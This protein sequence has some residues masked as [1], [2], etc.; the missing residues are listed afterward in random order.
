[1]LLRQRKAISSGMSSPGHSGF[2]IVR[3]MFYGSRA[4][5][6]ARTGGVVLDRLK[7]RDNK[8]SKKSDA[9]VTQDVLDELFWDPAVTVADLSVSTSDHRVTLMGTTATYGEKLEAEDAAYRVGGVRDV[10][11]DI[12]VDSSAF[13]MRSDEDIAADV[14]S[15]LILDYAVPDD[16][17]SVSVFEGT[18]TLAGNVDWYYQRLAAADDVAMIKGVKFVDN[19]IA[20]MQPEASATDISNGI[21]RAFARNAELYDDNVNVSADGGNVTLSGDVETWGEYDM[22]E[23]AAWRSPGVTS[24]TNNILVLAQ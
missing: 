19:D 14:R 2:S 22:A 21:A 12:A 1:M 4:N 6:D 8:L 11:N 24:V 5:S 10:D 18:V 23:D 15:A 7:E 20:V 9:Q 3:N 16:R 17:I 13:G